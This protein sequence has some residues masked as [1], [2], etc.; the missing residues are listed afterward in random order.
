MDNPLAR[1]RYLLGGCSATVRF[2]D[3]TEVLMGIIEAAQF[4]QTLLANGYEIVEP[5]PVKD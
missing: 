2:P 1:L 3:G 4:S 5:E